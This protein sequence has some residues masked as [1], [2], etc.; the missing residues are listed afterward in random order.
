MY[1]ITMGFSRQYNDDPRL[2]PSGKSAK[3]H[4]EAWLLQPMKHYIITTRL[5]D[6]LHCLCFDFAFLWCPCITMNVIVS[7]NSGLIPDILLLIQAPIFV[8]FG[9]NIIL[10]L[11]S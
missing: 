9:G 1:S 2:L 11:P 4:V 3:Y 8:W 5:D 6:V 10:L 7:Y